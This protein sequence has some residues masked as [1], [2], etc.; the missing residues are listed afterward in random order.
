MS[1]SE[2]IDLTNLINLQFR[3]DWVEDL[4]KKPDAAPGEVVWGRAPGAKFREERGERDDRPRHG[5]GPPRHDAGRGFER[6]PRPDNRGPR[7]EQ[8]GPRPPDN[9]GPRPEF[10]GPPAP[11]DRRPPPPR[12]DRRDSGPGGPRRDDRGGRPPFRDRDDRRGPP[13]EQG[14]FPLEGWAATL[15]PEPRSLESIARQIKAS[16]RAFS[17]FD[18]GRLFMQSRE[19]YLICFTRR[20]APPPQKP[21]DGQP[22]PPPAPAPRGP[23]EILRCPA[24]GSLWLTREEALRHLLHSPAIEKYYRTETVVTEAP[25][26]SWNAVAVCGFSGALLGPPNH[27]DY[28]RNVV[29]L[30][31]ERFSDMP[32]DRYK[33][34]IRVEK[35]E[36]LLTKWQEQQSSTTHWLPVTAEPL[37]EGAAAPAPLT[38]KSEMEAHFLRTFAADAVTPVTK[39][40]VPGTISE[41]GLAPALLALLRREVEHQQ[42]FPMQLVQDLCRALE[43]HGLRFFKRDKKTTF[44]SRNRPHFLPDDM[45]LSERI[46]T[47]V[48]IVRANPGI[49]YTQLVSTLAPQITVASPPAEPAVEAPVVEV[50]AE[51]TVAPAAEV[52]PEPAAVVPAVAPPGATAEETAEPVSLETTETAPDAPA[53]EA[54]PAEPAAEAPAAETAPAPAPPVHLSPAEI[55]IL[56]DL[57]WLVQE[58]Y[59]TEF[60]NGELFVLGRPPLPPMEKK[61]RAPRPEKSIVS[62]DS[63]AP[64]EA[65]GGAPLVSEVTAEEITPGD[66]ATP[67][68]AVARP[69]PAVSAAELESPSEPAPEQAPVP[70]V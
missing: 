40:T 23:Q 39:A 56:Q 24:D 31:R 66:D 12:G 28:Q 69:E 20:G 43:S 46:R 52:A 47:L 55:A 68:D 42:R 57:H 61:P 18:V 9:R 7:P 14:P 19:R 32:L 2:P 33:S 58:G 67:G 51:E 1:E 34:R 38:S 26:G 13:R 6:G 15:V 8:R 62:E 10:R 27:H 4:A 17:V 3:P 41:R 36:A 22:P 63:A 50:P 30:H 60:Q 29:R 16:G 49:K 44:V 54:A 35:D 48:E 11:G 37:P 64:V 25:K 45:V 5:G 53:A 59:V 21:K 70:A 65:V